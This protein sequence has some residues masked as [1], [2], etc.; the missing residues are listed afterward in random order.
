MVRLHGRN[1]E[2]WQAK[3]LASAA[4][5]FKYLYADAELKELATP[6]ADLENDAEEVHVIFN[7]CYSNFGVQNAVTFKEILGS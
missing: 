1:A 2:T 4:E 5:R 6:I 7:N 3:G